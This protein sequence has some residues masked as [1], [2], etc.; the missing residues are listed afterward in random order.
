MPREN[1]AEITTGLTAADN[2]GAAVVAEVA[3]RAA[4]VQD[5]YTGERK[6]VVAIN[7]RLETIELDRPPVRFHQAS[8][9]DALV[10]MA[11]DKWSAVWHHGD[12]VTL[13]LDNSDDSYRDDCVVWGLTRTDAYAAAQSG[14]RGADQKAAVELLTGKLRNPVRE[15][16][17]ASTLL[18]AIRRVNF[19]TLQEQSGTVDKVA[20]AVGKSVSAELVGAADLPEEFTIA[21]PRWAELGCVLAIELCVTVDVMRGQFTIAPTKDEAAAVEWQAQAQLAD[22]LVEKFAEAGKKDVPVFAGVP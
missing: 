13:V 20:E 15:S 8:S 19:K 2:S 6:K 21:V 12:T 5:V 11:V 9:V 14:V 18:A 4:A 10:A 17:A 7:G 3:T 22:Y 1:G 16:M